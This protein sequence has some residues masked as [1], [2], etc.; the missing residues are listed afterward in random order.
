MA[1]EAQIQGELPGWAGHQTESVVPDF[2]LCLSSPGAPP[3]HVSG[4]PGVCQ[5][6]L[7]SQIELEILPPLSTFGDHTSA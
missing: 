5:K 4:I 6:G 2:L 7:C 1:G 3:S